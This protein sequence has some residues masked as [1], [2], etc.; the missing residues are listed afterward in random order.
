M[1][2]LNHENKLQVDEKKQQTL[3][4]LKNYLKT[5]I[6]MNFLNNCLNLSAL[7]INIHLTLSLK[8][9]RLLSILQ[10]HTEQKRAVKKA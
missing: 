6:I 1:G 9:M 5:K 3:K 2:P 8:I 4:N 10:L 7:C